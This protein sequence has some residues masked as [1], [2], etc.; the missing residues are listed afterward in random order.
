MNNRN[1]DDAAVDSRFTRR[2]VLAYLAATGVWTAFNE[3]RVVAQTPAA[4]R[5]NKLT[6][7]GGAIDVHHHHMRPALTVGSNPWSPAV[8]LEQMDKFGIATSLLALTRM[9]DILYDGTERAGQRS[10]SETRTT[11]R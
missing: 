10:D 8:S 6:A 9:G 5:V 2:E 7:R 1:R 11:R 3:R 4:E